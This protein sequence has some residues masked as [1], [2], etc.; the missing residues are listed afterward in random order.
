MNGPHQYNQ[1][2]VKQTELTDAELDQLVTDADTTEREVGQALLHVT[3]V[4]MAASLVA[5]VV[6]G[7]FGYGKS[8]LGAAEMGLVALTVDYAMYRWLRISKRLRKQGTIT[9][10]GKALDWLAFLMSMYLN[11]CG[12]LA[13]LIPPLSPQAYGLLTVAHLFIPVMFITCHKAMPGAQLLLRER[14][15][16]GRIERDRRRQDAIDRQNA[17]ELAK[18][19]EQNEVT[20]TTNNLATAQANEKTRQHEANIA[21]A[22]ADVTIAREK[23][24]ATLASVVFLSLALQRP[25]QRRASPSRQGSPASRQ[26]RPPAGAPASRKPAAGALPQTGADKPDVEKLARLAEAALAEH[27]G[28]GRGQLARELGVS[29]YFARLALEFLNEERAAAREAGLMAI[30]ES[31]GQSNG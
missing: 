30:L 24:A 13:T 12:G 28:M 29:T 25:R 20:K 31:G 9:S 19:R 26:A 18:Q 10:A 21:R 7:Y 4:A 16:K 1:H 23:L 2:G 8:Y 11:G 22:E 3:A 15:E 14:A 5:S 27:P 17:A 6:F